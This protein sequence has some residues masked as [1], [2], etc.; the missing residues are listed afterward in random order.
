MYGSSANRPYS[1]Q[2]LASSSRFLYAHGASNAELVN[3]L[4]ARANLQRTPKPANSKESFD[5]LLGNQAPKLSAEEKRIKTG[6]YDMANQ[7]G[8]PVAPRL[9]VFST[10]ELEN[11][12]KLQEP[13]KVQQY[14]A[15]AVEK[16][17]GQSQRAKQSVKNMRAANT[18][19]GKAK[20]TMQVVESSHYVTDD[21][22][23]ATS[24]VDD[25]VAKKRSRM[26]SGGGGGS[27]DDDDYFETPYSDPQEPEPTFELP[28]L[29][30]N[31]F[32]VVNEVFQ[33]FWTMDFP[34]EKVSTAFFAKIDLENCRDYGLTTFTE[35]P[36]GLAIIRDRIDATLLAKQQ[37][38]FG[39]PPLS[40]FGIQPYRSIN[41]VFLDFRQMFDNI[42]RFFPA[43]HPAL[44]VAREL[45]QVFATKWAEAQKK[46]K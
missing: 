18:A 36:S 24:I 20:K 19:A 44:P 39:G 41:D 26:S 23:A 29:P 34:E 46:F 5:H 2:S 35:S 28:P 12:L 40:A 17:Q 37:D 16:P 25:I 38:Q 42:Y 6:L 11:E 45:D 1:S 30:K 31:F 8:L 4:F 15:P 7:Q 22:F 10:N 13:R 33:H 21:I 14:V 43:E 27:N 32:E 3:I 9:W